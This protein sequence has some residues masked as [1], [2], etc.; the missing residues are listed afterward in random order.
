MLLYLADSVIET[1]EDNDN[2]DD[3]VTTQRTHSSTHTIHTS[4][5]QR[6]QSQKQSKENTEPLSGRKTFSGQSQFSEEIQNSTK[7]VELVKDTQQISD[8]ALGNNI[9]FVSDKPIQISTTL[10]K[11]K[12][13][14]SFTTN[15]QNEPNQ[16]SHKT[17][18]QRAIDQKTNETNRKQN[19]NTSEVNEEKV[20]LDLSQLK[21]NVVTLPLTTLSTP[22]SES[23]NCSLPLSLYVNEL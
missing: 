7:E 4:T 8:V 1:M 17:K 16:T 3:E 11:I 6:E 9:T 12:K 13:N 23:K 19:E 14:K 21:T 15:T 18:S 10:F 22:V 2:D 5:T 20:L